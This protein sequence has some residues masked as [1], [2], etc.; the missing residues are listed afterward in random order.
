M[1]LQDLRG[2][3]PP[4]D[5][6][7]FQMPCSVI[8][9]QHT[10]SGTT[11]IVAAR[12]GDRGW[13]LV[14][15]GTVAS[16]VI[17][18]ALAIAG[19]IFICQGTYSITVTL[20]S[21]SI[22]EIVG[23]G[24]TTILRLANGADCNVITVGAD[25]WVI[26]D[27]KI[28]GNSAGQGVGNW[29]GIVIDSRND[30]L[31]DN[32]DV[33]DID[34]MG[35]LL[36]GTAHQWRIVSSQFYLNQCAAIFTFAATFRVTVCNCAFENNALGVTHPDIEIANGASGWVITNCVSTGGG[37]G[38][39]YIHGQ[40]GAPPHDI[41]VTNC[42]VT[43]TT[44]GGGLRAGY[45]A[46]NLTI[47]GNTLYNTYYYSIFIQAC[48]NVVIDGNSIYLASGWSVGI[49]GVGGTGSTFIT[50]SDNTIY[51]S[52]QSDWNGAIR[53][54]GTDGTIYDIVIEGN[55]IYDDRGG[56][57]VNYCYQGIDLMA[58]VHRVTIN[59]NNISGMGQFGV[60]FEA[61]SGGNDCIISNNTIF[62][63]N[64]GVDLRDGDDISILDNRI[65]TATY[66]INVGNAAVTRA[67]VYGNCLQG[68]GVCINDVGTGTILPTLT[69]AFVDGSFSVT[70]DGAPK[71]WLVGATADFAIAYG[72]M[73]S[74]CQQTLR[75]KVWAVGLA[76]PGANNQMLI[77]LAANG[78]QAH[79]VYTGETIAV[80]SKES[81]ETDFSINDVI[82][83]TFTPADDAD[84]GHLV[85]GDCLE[86]K[87]IYRA[88]GAPDAA[89]NALFRCIEIQYV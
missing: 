63:T 37:Y 9:Y 4:G 70:V 47:S 52:A 74:D 30:G 64:I 83:W 26:R 41:S 22:V 20:T 36:V 12:Q 15:H 19:E 31:I 46:F 14:G 2:Q 61:A 69:L 55:T 34:Y 3:G 28:D 42:Y 16:T 18:A 76:A 25:H 68:C 49:I 33:T 6:G 13:V 56:A 73:P 65:N 89:T 23:T 84:I 77:D 24:N 50:I 10:F 85:A 79:E 67:R 5:I 43:A 82:S 51:N 17:N 7:T 87:L 80:N 75:M 57:E 35:I 66:G 81:N 86:I 72:V 53:L 88:A 54:D 11:Y 1:S 40:G 39:V 60:Y 44:N 38:F 27:L 71:G 48:H 32:V 58:G 78:A 45:G 29:S 59:A 8:V 21:A 62:S